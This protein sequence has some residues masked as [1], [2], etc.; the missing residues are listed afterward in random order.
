[1]YTAEHAIDAL[2][3]AIERLNEAT[4]RQSDPASDHADPPDRAVS[5][6]IS[7]APALN[8]A[9]PPAPA[10]DLS[11]ADAELGDLAFDDVADL[12]ASVESL[13]EPIEQETPD[14]DTPPPAARNANAPIESLSDSENDEAA[15]DVAEDDA[16]DDLVAQVMAEAVEIDDERDADT[17][18]NGAPSADLDPTAHA[19]GLAATESAD[20]EPEAEADTNPEPPAASR[21]HTPRPHVHDLS[22]LIAEDSLPPSDV[23]DPSFDALPT[24]DVDIALPAKPAEETHQPEAPGAAQSFATPQREA[25][26]AAIPTSPAD[27]AA[28]ID[29]DL[30]ASGDA[31]DDDETPAAT[32]DERDPE[33]AS[34]DADELALDELMFDSIDAVTAPSAADPAATPTI[35]LPPR[36]PTPV[37][38]APEF[39]APAVAS[40]ASASPAPT[41]V[42][43]AI[44]PAAS[45]AHLSLPQRLLDMLAPLDSPTRRLLMPLNMPLRLLPPSARQIV[46]AIAATLPVWVPVVW[47]IIWHLRS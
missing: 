24:A 30:D 43:A 40:R 26:P 20:I 42:P 47:F 4:E 6:P 9:Q 35:E 17:E 23:I 21:A 36:A 11:D 7:N 2:L 12:L 8:A 34:A 13:P 45:I 32:D 31:A 18:E 1:M 29:A 39:T 22:S 44:A 41:E 16:I 5:A 19:E 15:P 46:N 38:I 37:Q 10:N 27:S 25:P 33:H 28:D 14:Q 3:H